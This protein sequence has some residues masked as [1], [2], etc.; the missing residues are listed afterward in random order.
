M[1]STENPPEPSEGR[2]EQVG[3]ALGLDDRG[4]LR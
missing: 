2:F 4:R 3:Q 1:L